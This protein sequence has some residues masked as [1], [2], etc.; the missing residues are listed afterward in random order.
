MPSERWQRSTQVKHT[1]VTMGMKAP[2][3]PSLPFF[4]VDVTML[5]LH[6]NNYF[7]KKKKKCEQPIC[8]LWLQFSKNWGR[9]P[10][11]TWQLGI[12]FESRSEVRSGCHSA[13]RKSS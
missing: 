8:D 5:Q 10:E 9:I 11:S 7:A 6:V 1:V 12:N 3:L 4:S 13:S 2:M